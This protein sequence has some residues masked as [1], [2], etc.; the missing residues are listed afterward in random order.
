[1]KPTRAADCQG[2]G[3]FTAETNCYPYLCARCLDAKGPFGQREAAH[4]TFAGI[5]VI[6]VDTLPPNTMMASPD[7]YEMLA[8]TPE[9]RAAKA[10]QLL[11]TMQSMSDKLPDLTGGGQK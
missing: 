4:P 2:C 11:K 9:E 3:Q 5:K 6:R 7:V 8:A 1:M 10:E